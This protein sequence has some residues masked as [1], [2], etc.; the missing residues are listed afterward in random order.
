[1]KNLGINNQESEDMCSVDIDGMPLSFEGGYEMFENLPN[2]NQSRFHCDDG[3][4]NA[5]LMENNSTCVAESNIPLT[6][7]TANAIEVFF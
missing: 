7:E 4:L 1:M 2:N 5:L 6:T 3:G